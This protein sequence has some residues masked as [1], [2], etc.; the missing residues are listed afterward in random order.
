MEGVLIASSFMYFWA[1]FLSA[2]RSTKP[3]FEMLFTAK[4]E[5]Y[6]LMNELAKK[7]MAKNIQKVI[8]PQKIWGR[9]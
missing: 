9:N 6:V 5:I 2:F 3:A 4:K 7:G 1:I 8:Y